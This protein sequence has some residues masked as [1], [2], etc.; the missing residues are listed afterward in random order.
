MNEWLSKDQRPPTAL[1]LGHWDITQPWPW[2]WHFTGL[3]VPVGFHAAPSGSLCLQFHPW[4]RWGTVSPETAFP[5]GFLFLHSPKQ[6]SSEH[7]YFSKLHTLGHNTNSIGF[8][9]RIAYSCPWWEDLTKQT[10]LVQ[11]ILYYFSSLVFLTDLRAKVNC[12]CSSQ[13]VLFN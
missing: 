2:A 9:D 3:K 11:L 8:R 7:W 13:L 12:T 10:L 6:K 4:L 5:Q 1:S